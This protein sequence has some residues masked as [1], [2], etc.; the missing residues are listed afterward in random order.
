[1]SDYIKVYGDTASVLKATVVVAQML[2]DD[3]GEL[4]PDCENANGN[5]GCL[6]NT[7]DGCRILGCPLARR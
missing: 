2:N 4:S 7:A 3:F 1:M 5:G 6:I